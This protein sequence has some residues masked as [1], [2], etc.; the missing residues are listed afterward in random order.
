MKGFTQFL[1]IYIYIYILCINYLEAIAYI[2]N[3]IFR[4]GIK[5]NKM[6][7]RLKKILVIL[8]ITQHVSTNLRSFFLIVRLK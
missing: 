1:Q 5:Y 8:I 6:L 3:T 4:Y 7:N 2:F